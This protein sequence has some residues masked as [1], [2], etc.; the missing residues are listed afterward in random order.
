MDGWP[1]FCL[2][3]QGQV[4][5]GQTIKSRNYLGLSHYRSSLA[6]LESS[7]IEQLEVEPLWVEIIGAQAIVD[8]TSIRGKVITNH[9]YLIIPQVICD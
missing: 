7:G 3:L 4:V 9:E 8:A 5:R 1:R 2:V 6:E